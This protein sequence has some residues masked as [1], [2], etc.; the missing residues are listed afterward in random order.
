MIRQGWSVRGPILPGVVMGILALSGGLEAQEHPFSHLTFPELTFHPP[1]AEEHQVA[2]VTVYHLHDPSIPLVDFFLQLRGGVSHFPR[3][4][5]VR[6]GALPSLLRNGGTTHLPPDSVDLRLDLLA[7]QLSVGSGGGGSFAALNTLTP[8]FPEALALLRDLLL[9]P[10]FDGE[11]VE[12]WRRQEL[13]RI[14]RRGDDPG[15]LAFSEFNRLLFGDHPVGWVTTEEELAPEALDGEA[16]RATHRELVCRDRLLLGVAGDLDWNEARPLVER[17]LAGWPPCPAPLNVPPPAALR[18]GPGIYI[19]HRPLEQTTVI[20]AQESPIRQRD[21]PDFFASR[22]ANHL[23][24]ASGF[25]SR[26]MARVRTE[27]GLAYGASSIWTT[28]VNHPGL[29]GALTATRSDRVPR[30]VALLL[31]ELERFRVEPPTPA[32]VERA[33]DEIRNG[34][35]FAFES[36]AG[37]VARQMS[38]RSQELPP[39]WLERFLEGVGEVTPE[40]L[41]Q[42][43]REVID[44]NR[45]VILLVGDASTFADALEGVGPRFRLESDGTIL[46]WDGIPAPEAPR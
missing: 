27:E 10:G 39:G 44:P 42:V 12:I 2:G 31:D 29:V 18:E 22:V 28:P 1:E 6:I 33:L 26:L 23:L 45:M 43:V 5:Q 7:A 20:L 41:A 15:T 11:A 40:T 25:G 9:D 34:Y 35:V 36:A 17:F 30:A 37:I 4:E 3:S 13:E 46:P 16:L 24:G 32:E 19:L 38:Y 21:T 8:V 14:R